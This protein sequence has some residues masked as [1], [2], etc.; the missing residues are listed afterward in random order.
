MFV[1]KKSKSSSRKPISAANRG[2]KQAVVEEKRKISEVEDVTAKK[3]PVKP[4][5]KQELE[6]ASNTEIIK[7]DE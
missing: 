5:K 7:T 2:V 6:A 4:R 3:K 1:F